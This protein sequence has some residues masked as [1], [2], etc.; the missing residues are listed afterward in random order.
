M[1]V[2]SCRNYLSCVGS[3]NMLSLSSPEGIVEDNDR[4][5]TE[6]THDKQFP[7]EKTMIEY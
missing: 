3:V 2:F 5:L 4:I 6:P 1:I 7:E